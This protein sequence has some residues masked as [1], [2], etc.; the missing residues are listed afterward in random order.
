MYE[1]RGTRERPEIWIVREEF[2]ILS[3]VWEILGGAQEELLMAVSS[4]TNKMVGLL[5]I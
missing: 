2:N 5:P 4:I 3:K 1:R